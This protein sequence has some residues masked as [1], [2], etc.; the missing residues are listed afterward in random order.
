MKYPSTSKL[1]K[2]FLLF[3]TNGISFLALA[4]KDFASLVNPF[5]GTGGHGHTYPG[6]SAPFGMMQ[7][8]PDTRMADWDGSSGYHYSDS[9]IYGFSHTHLSGTGIP[10][11]CDLLFMPYTGEVKWNNKDYRSRFSHKNEKA[12]PGYYEVMLDR[13][14]IKAQLSTSVRSGMHQYSFPSSET[15]GSILIDLKHRDQVLESWVEKVSPTELRGLRRS[16]SWAKD[17]YLYFY[18]RFENPIESFG[19]RGDDGRVQNTAFM[20][21][22]D[23]RLFV[24][25][26]LGDTKQ[27]RAKVGISAVSADGAKLNLDTEIPGWD[28]NAVKDAA[29]KAWNR[30]LSKIEIKGG[31]RDQQVTFYTALYHTFLAPNIFQDVDGQYR[32]T[33]NT[34]HK[35]AINTNYSV[36]S[37]WDTYRGYHPLMTIINQQRT[38]D[39]I[40]TFLRQ[41]EQGGM[42]PV[43]EL[44]GNETFC[45]IG[46][47]SVPVIVD[48]YQKGIRDFNTALALK[49]MRSYAESE[50]FGLGAY[51]RF[52]YIGNEKEHESVSKTLEY[53]YD[54]W[55]IAQFA[56]M[57]G[58]DSAYRTY[59]LRA[60]YYKNVFDPSTKHMRG[61]IQARWQTPFD[62]REVNNFFTEGNAWQYSFAVPHDIET[63][64]SMHGGVNAFM[65]KLDELFTTNSQLTGRDQADV[66]GLIGQ[67]AH[68][69]E[70]SHHM[71]YLF[72]YLGKPSRTQELV[73]KICN[74]FYQNAPDGLIGNEDC[75]QM[76]AWYILSSM[77]FYPVCPGNGD[78]VLGTPLFDEVKINLENG[79]QFTIKTN[80]RSGNDFYI[81]STKL[82]GRSQTKSFLLHEDIIKG[83]TFEFNLASL[84]STTWGMAEADR[85]RSKINE[86]QI[87]PVPYFDMS[88]N[89]FR[90]RTEV[91]IKTP[92]TADEVKVMIMDKIERGNYWTSAP[93]MLYQGPFT[94]DSTVMV[95][96][97]A[98]KNADSSKMVEQ[99][100]Y[101]MH[102]DRNI[103][104][105]SQVH[106]MYTAGGPD[107][108]VDG[109]IGMENWRTGAWQ[110]Y[111][112]QDFEAIIELKEKRKISYVG[113]HVLQEI[114]P[115]I[116]FPKE[117][118][119]SVSNDGKTFT[120]T[121]RIK[122]NI[123][124][125]NAGPIARELGGAVKAE[126]KFIKVK[127]VNG[128]KL[129]ADHE[130]AG[131]GSHLFI[132]EVII[133]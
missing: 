54:D 1:L 62:P 48:A 69:N 25:F 15:Q 120:E 108:L 27:V 10:D 99:D 96:A 18:I 38:K 63:L 28:F 47:H 42:L 131:N 118:I 51:K 34:I 132:D 21:G 7:L 128:G 46:Y 22:K 71:A 110:S 32:G 84:P 14:G 9:V 116:I 53:A 125:M 92:G 30:E 133:R 58:K 93:E 31:T 126:T 98:I 16:K 106:P 36:F 86:A 104:V 87:V 56:R 61:K 20:Q 12:F 94:I 79:K 97:Y 129:P 26:A 19:M 130:S 3:I 66:T 83:G 119:V 117:L 55:C 4:Q 37:L 45:M 124:V 112:D 43:W 122:N 109:I 13:Q 57:T 52:G 39:W 41:Y 82:N 33:G 77:G 73:Q 68:G 6:A 121:A 107:A 85:P 29:S 24:Q 72:N 74:N 40:H 78:Y 70:P 123:G 50:R 80:R 11:Y 91:K 114:S 89:T 60:Q 95:M 90:E 65:S 17:Q 59:I 103:K 113:V 111:F 67:Y 100:L 88:S 101:K 76:S 35:A 23:V 75:G 8:S 5:I 102:N 127:A 49:A 115:W 2:V 64:V 44:A 81:T 105:L